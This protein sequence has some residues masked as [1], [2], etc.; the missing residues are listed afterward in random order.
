MYGHL[1]AWS[2]CEYMAKRYDAA[3]SLLERAEAYQ[4]SDS[5]ADLLNA[6]I[7]VYLRRGDSV[8]FRAALAKL[9]SLP[10]YEPNAP[11]RLGVELSIA[12]IRGD[13]A[14]TLAVGGRYQVVQPTYGHDDP[15]I[16]PELRRAIAKG[17]KAGPL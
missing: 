1:T 7:A 12:E 17:R 2:G 9:Y 10:G 3:D 16:S 13:V 11:D 6:R 15:D 5:G 8:A 4:P 14:A